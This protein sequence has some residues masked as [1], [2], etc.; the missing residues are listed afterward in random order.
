VNDYFCGENNESEQIIGFFNHLEILLGSTVSD[1][2]ICVDITGFMRPQLI[3]LIT[4]LNY[5]GI[6]NFDVIYTEPGQYRK[7]ENTSFSEGNIVEVRQVNGFEGSHNH[8]TGNDLLIIGAGYDDKLISSVA[9]DKEHAKKLQLIG[10]PSLMP[11]MYQQN[12]LKVSKSAES[13]GEESIS[14]PYFA[15]ANNPFATAAKLSSMVREFECKYGEITNLYLSPLSTKPQVLGF[16][17][18]FIFERGA[19]N[20]S[21][22]FP[23]SEFYQR[24]TSQGV[25]KILK[26]KV[27][28]PS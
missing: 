6:K 14:K 4:Y 11:D 24:E 25:S 12:L 3:F 7:Q 17:L 10:F 27:E 1:K 5:F 20:T 22:I 16:C 13:L 26:Y 15:A 9:D 2:S 21:V 8:E 23:F 18:Y 19:T 28:L